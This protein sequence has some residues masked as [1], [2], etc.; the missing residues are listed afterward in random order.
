MVLVRNRVDDHDIPQPAHV[1]HRHLD[2]LLRLSLNMLQKVE[3]VGHVL[4]VGVMAAE[5]LAVRC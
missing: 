3:M 4:F 2:L 1:L 5:V